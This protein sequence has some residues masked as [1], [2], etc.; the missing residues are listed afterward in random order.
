[1]KTFLNEGE[2]AAKVCVVVGTRPSIVLMS[3]VIKE[4]GHRGLP[5]FVLHT[6]QH[7]SPNMDQVF[8]DDLELPPPHYNLESVRHCT[9]HGSQTAEML[10]G[11]EE[12]LLSERPLIVLVGGDANCHLAGALAARK[13]HMR[14]GH[15]EAGER[16]YH[17]H[18]PEE[19]NRVI[20]DHISDYLFATNAKAQDNL[21]RESVRGEI[22]ITGNPKTDAALQIREIAGH[23]S[24][25]LA[26]LNLKSRDYIVLTLHRE[27]NVDSP[28]AMGRVLQTLARI[29]GELG[30]RLVFPLHPRTKKNLGL[31]GLADKLSQVDK[32][33]T[34]DALGY[35]DFVQL[36]SQ[37]RL[38]L[39]DSGGVQLES[40]VFRVPCVTLR[41]NTEW[42]ETIELGINTLVGTDPDRILRG[43][44]KVLDISFPAQVPF[45]DGQAADR[46]VDILTEQLRA[47]GGLAPIGKWV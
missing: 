24:G 45:G 44:S 11:I 1:M 31:F 33:I 42:L 25:I 9:H 26:T 35:L 43:I 34:C 3:P 28:E 27:E 46:I 7:Y 32:L 37:A 22:F 5:H 41:E 14:V 4:L 19:H 29:T 12:I 20:I 21:A 30:F 47:H 38:V 13:L 10:R 15:V 40:C 18:M 16:S 6:G 17:W 8:F 39:T 23:K 36:L 2:L